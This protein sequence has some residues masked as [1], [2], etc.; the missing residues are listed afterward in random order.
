[1]DD[2]AVRRA[3]SQSIDYR[4]LIEKVAH[5]AGEEAYNSLPPTAIGYEKLAPHK[6]DPA[7]ANALLDRRGWIRGADGI[8]EK[9]GARLSFTIATIT[10]STSIARNAL[11]IQQTLHDTGIEIAI[12]PYP[13]NSIFAIDGPIYSGKYDMAIYSTTLTW[14]PNVYF[15]L[16]CDKWYPRGENTYRYCNPELDALESAGLQTDD[17]DERAQIYRKASRIIWDTIPYL[18]LYELRRPFVHSVDLKN[19]TDNPSATPW[20]NAWQWDI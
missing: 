7:A 2:V 14:D 6:F 4:A 8:R 15:Y 16:A 11:Q 20:W 10:G 13:Y 5:G 17:S 1:L 18:P 3:I 9:N 19:I 12:K